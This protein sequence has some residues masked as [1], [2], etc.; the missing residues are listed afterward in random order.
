[1]DY[2]DK[3]TGDEAFKYRFNVCADTGDAINL[4]RVPANFERWIVGRQDKNN[5]HSM[6][7]LVSIFGR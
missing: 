1:M 2:V 3:I 4:R 6:R 5:F 7:P